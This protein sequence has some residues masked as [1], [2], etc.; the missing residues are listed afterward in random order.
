MGCANTKQ[1]GGGKGSEE[2]DRLTTV[3]QYG[4]AMKEGDSKKA[5]EFVADNVTWN[6]FTGSTI[7][8]KS[9][10]EAYLDDNKKQG[11]TRKALS[12]WWLEGK[13]SAD[14]K[15]YTAKRQIQYTKADKGPYQVLQTFEVQNG[16]ITKADVSSLPWEPDLDPKEILC[17]Y[18]SLRAQNRTTDAMKCIADECEWFPFKFQSIYAPSSEFKDQVCIIGPNKIEAL[19]KEQQGQQVVREALSD[20]QEGE[21][22]MLAGA[23]AREG[24]KIFFRKIEIKGKKGPAQTFEQVTQ[25]AGGKIV[26][27]IHNRDGCRV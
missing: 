12:Y 3:I 7:S 19:W 8:G 20:W 9:N 14:G 2:D 25:V 21:A 6:T 26:T 27:V 24:N 10:L 15:S 4:A 11:V 1:P 16:F 23:T 17:R 22:T 5:L 18:A 13:L